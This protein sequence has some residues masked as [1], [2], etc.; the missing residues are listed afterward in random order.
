MLKK[1]NM[2]TRI[3]LSYAFT[4]MMIE[5]AD[6]A[7]MVI[8][9]LII[10][11]NLGPTM[12]AATGLGSTS[13]QMILL[14]CGAFAVGLQSTCSSA[15]GA[16]DS[17][18]TSRYFTSGL[19]TVSSIALLL[20][21]FGFLFLDPL[22]RL[23]GADGSDKLL[24]SGLHEYLRG[25]FVGI[26]GLIAFTVLC[27]L[28]TL[29]GNKKVVVV[30]TILESALNIC[31]DYFSVIHWQGDQLSAIYGIGFS[32][33][34]SFDLVSVVLLASFLR[35]RSAFKINI[36]QFRLSE[37]KE[38]LRIGMPRLTKYACKLISPL[39]VNRTVLAVGGSCAMAAMSVKSSIT[40]FCL[41]AGNG[42]A[43]SINLLSQ[44][45]YS[46]KDKK[47]LK[48]TALDA[49][50][51]VVVICTS[52]SVVL[53]ALSPQISAIFLARGTEEYRL[54]VIMMRCF[55]LSLMLNGLNACVL[56]YLQGTR[57]ILPAHLQTVSFRLA[58]LTLCTVV[59]GYSF[60]IAGIFAAIPISELLVLLTYIVVASFFGH[61]KKM[62]DA[63]MLIPEN[64]GCNDDE[65]LAF[66]VTTPEEV[67]GISET[68]QAFCMSHGIDKRRAYFSALCVE[69]TAGNVVGHGFK[70]DNKEH[71][72]DIRVMIENGDIILRIR[73]DCRYFN[74]KERYEVLKN[75]DAFSG[76]GIKLVYGAAKEINYVNLL[77]T[78]TLIIRV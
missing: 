34:A 13:F 69:E 44:V 20:T 7:S 55:A 42:I 23:L 76:I 24:Y 48:E 33:G 68:V 43:E 17:E 31:G 66:S 41:V 39:L 28:A 49:V 45:Y 6:S 40:G 1:N 25:M 71:N 73:D 74:M 75:Q 60:G 37:V 21:V 11:R 3:M 47:A 62:A 67:T 12:L 77:N 51:L 63:L 38:M 52:L 46:E 14:F 10:S 78:N 26:P 15:M 50:K 56:N 70:K 4:F 35:K 27:P 57:K 18:R 9:G 2:T 30:A 53:F 19:L 32:S 59:L 72:C 54:S 58:F 8:D 64:F 16:G 36:M 29:D 5:L 65:N 61:G 22:C